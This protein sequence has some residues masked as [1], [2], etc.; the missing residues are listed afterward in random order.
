MHTYTQNGRNFII[1]EL[2]IADTLSGELLAIDRQYYS[3]AIAWSKDTWQ[4]I[5]STSTYK[6]AVRE[7][8]EAGSVLIG[9]M[10]VSVASGRYSS[11]PDYSS[12]Y[13]NSLTIH[14]AYLRQ[15]HAKH[16]CLELKNMVQGDPESKIEHVSVFVPR[17]KVSMSI[18]CEDH[19]FVAYEVT[20]RT[21]RYTTSLN[22]FCAMVEDKTSALQ[23]SDQDEE[24]QQSAPSSSPRANMC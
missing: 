17:N 22:D 1:D 24:E 4:K 11:K 13:I 19:G 6:L 2:T 3:P 15:G 7:I 10:V 9:H 23:F 5:L 12:Y 18:L 21:V 16:L 20:A 8:T 14:T